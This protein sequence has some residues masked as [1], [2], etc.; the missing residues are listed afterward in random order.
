MCRVH[1]LITFIE[2]LAASLLLGK[3]CLHKILHK[4]SEAAMIQAS[5]S[6]SNASIKSATPLDLLILATFIFILPNMNLSR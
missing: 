6:V 4:V 1:C 5:F 3:L 2:H